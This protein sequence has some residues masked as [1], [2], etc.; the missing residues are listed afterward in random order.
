MLVASVLAVVAG[1]AAQA[2]NTASEVL[3]DTDDDGVGDARE[4]GGRDRYD[5]A[6]RLAAN[7]G[8]AKG[9]GNV[10]VAFVA[11]GE[12]LVDAVSVSGL[13][14][15]FDAPVLLTPS[16]SLHGGV[17]DF[18]E[19]YGVGTVHVL[20]GS[21]AVAD[22]V[23]ED[24]EA[25]ANGPTVNRV[26]GADRYATAAAAA[27]LLGGG[28][29]WCGGEDAAAVL[30][31]GGDV[32]LVDA[33][34]VGP[35]AYRLQ[36]PVLLT[37]A[38]VL[39][40]ATADFIEANDIEH[41]VIVGGADAVSAD[42]ADAVSDSGVDTVT[43]VAGD[44]PA[45]T[46]VALAE[47]AFDGC[48]DDLAPVSDDTV[49]LVHRDALP[50]GVA[51]APV[52]AS[53]FA[54]GTL[55]PVLVVGDTLPAAVRDY[56]AATAEEDADG[57]K[58]HFNILAIGGTAAVSSDVMDAAL[59][60]AASAPALTVQIG[61]GGIH[62]PDNATV[63]D[64]KDVNED[65]KIDA[66]DLPQ[67]GDDQITLYF[68]DNVMGGDDLEQMIRDAI[69]LNGVPALL[70]ATPVTH[71]DNSGNC[72]ADQVTVTFAN[73]LKAGDTVAIAAGLKL[74][75]DNDQRTVGGASV[76]VPAPVPDRTRPI[77]NGIGIVGQNVFL[78]SIT[79]DNLPS[80]EALTIADF[81]LNSPAGNTLQSVFWSEDKPEGRVATRNDGV[82]QNDRIKAGD[83][84]TVKSGAVED[85]AGNR[86]LRRSFTAIAPHKSPRITSVLLSNLNHTD[87]AT[88]PVPADFKA[89]DAPDAPTIT[90]KPDG[91][92]AGAAGND[93]RLVFDV[94]STW[95]DDEDAAV[96]ID[97]WVN[98]RD[99]EVS[100]RFNTGNAT[101]GDL[102]AA[103][104]A[105]SAFDALFDVELALDS[106]AS[107]ARTELSLGTTDSHRQIAVS[108]EGGET[109]VAIQVTFNGYIASIIDGD[110]AD[111]QTALLGDILA[112]TI[113]RGTTATPPL[114]LAAV[115]AALSLN[116]NASD[117]VRIQGPT[118]VV[119]YE[120]VTTDAAMLPQVRDLVITEAGSGTNP[121]PVAYGYAMDDPNTA[122]VDESKNG[123]SRVFIG[124]SSSVE[125][126]K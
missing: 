37:S 100:V 91:A 47:L 117:F 107:T 111:V 125:A 73:P 90:A 48:A 84:L 113:A 102:K 41:V 39:A 123:A 121:Q 79:D 72:V 45:G 11:S 23:V 63:D 22:S 66:N 112:A 50:D 116:P 71:T 57:N 68:S 3:V 54:A 65:G 119:R 15:F 58:V 55:V 109:K 86:S 78:V 25:L 101:Y 120:T 42:V 59:A 124:R 97:V 29:A 35:I 70:A 118:T 67:A 31:N 74:G 2:A 19:D 51:S 80:S 75:V 34:M 92:A 103:L 53:T 40:S 69:E 88:I 13:A 115:L 9:L 21:G 32:S 26:A 110:D 77:V 16:D 89:D 82:G 43:R 108:L 7:F 95:E 52:L 27:G 24:L 10:P 93:W 62:D 96:D 28:A 20:G 17:A 64:R 6:L 18:V 36:L 76:T 56:L 104:E 12:S 105:N 60:A 83:R 49:A 98:Q 122:N 5:T 114:D 126:P 81:E 14:G 44:T 33:M 87:Q 85:A 61:H 8:A 94:L 106:C 30:V 99:R 1:S 46:S 4:F 38:G